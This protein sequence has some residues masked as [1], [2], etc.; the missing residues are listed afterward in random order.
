MNVNYLKLMQASTQISYLY[1]LVIEESNKYFPST[2]EERLL[3]HSK[4]VDY[5]VMLIAAYFWK[6]ERTS[7]FL[8]PMQRELQWVPEYSEFT[9]LCISW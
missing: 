7:Y 6:E 4:K 3:Q 2:P 9:S 5:I 8:S 1:S